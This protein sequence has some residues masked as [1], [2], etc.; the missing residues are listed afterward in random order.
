M[1]NEIKEEIQAIADSL[2]GIGNE[3]CYR[4]PDNYF[5]EL[6][7]EVMDKIQLPTTQL[8]FTAPPAAYFEG[9]AGAILHKIKSDGIIVEADSEVTQEL[10][11]LSPVMASINKKNVYTVPAD[12]FTTFNVN[13][14]KTTD[15]KGKMLTMPQPV[16]WMRYAAA[17]AVIGVVAISGIFLFRNNT[18]ADNSTHITFTKDYHVPLSSISDDAIANYLKTS[19]AADMDLIPS[20]YDETMINAGNLTE[21]LLQDV[22][23]SDIQDYLK[24]NQQP[25]EKEIK[26][27]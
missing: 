20:A 23:D 18:N 16:R 17:A 2:A 7:D 19:P 21:Q 9:L 13:I 5:E 8:P 3:N 10:R 12:Y 11:E 4:V 1:R 6:A 14:P 24:E 25:G 26:G 27:I 15:R 22:S